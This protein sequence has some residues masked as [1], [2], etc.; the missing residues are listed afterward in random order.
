MITKPIPS[1]VRR[2]PP[3]NALVLLGLLALLAAAAGCRSGPR[4]AVDLLYV[5]LD[6]SLLD[7]DGAVP[8]VNREAVARFRA[9]G[10]RVGVATGRMPDAG[11]PHA[12][13]IGAGLPAILAN[14]AVVL[15]EGGRPLRIEAMADAEAV[16]AMCAVVRGAGCQ[17][18]Y[19]AHAELDSGRVRVE[20]GRCRA[21]QQAGWWA[22]KLRAKRCP[23]HHGLLAR[24]QRISA[25]RQTVI[26]SGAGEWLGVSISALGATKGQAIAFV[27]ERLGVPLA[28]VAFVGDGGNDVSA[29]RTLTAAGGRCFA[30]ANAV[31]ALRTVCPENT[32]RPHHRGAVAEAIDRL[33]AGP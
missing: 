30:V 6:G 32:A 22:I 1:R 15:G 16:E 9:A 31:D 11:L 13:T 5:D 28:R 27:A 14:G 26:E 7:E 29:G 3:S 10:G 21:P 8:S 25:G 24:L 17:A 19:V 2:R 23:D 4:P 18:I 20:R 12:R 33:L